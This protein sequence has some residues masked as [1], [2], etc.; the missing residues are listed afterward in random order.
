M[1][2]DYTWSILAGIISGL[3]LG[4]FLKIMELLTGAKVYILL[5]NID[6]V[7]ILKNFQFPEWSEFGLH[8]LISIA[9]SLILTQYMNGREWLAKQ[10]IKFVT[11]VSIV[12]GILLYPTTLLSDRTP[13][14]TDIT[15]MILWLLG[16]VLYG[17]ILGYML[18]KE[19]N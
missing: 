12:V 9:L 1:K 2:N 4:F 13:E 8:I 3:I 10:R 19:R 14:F 17:A 16:H 5:L 15:A 11:L 7:P 6:Y 18:R